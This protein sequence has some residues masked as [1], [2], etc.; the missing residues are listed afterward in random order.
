LKVLHFQPID[1]RGWFL[2]SWFC[3]NIAITV[4]QI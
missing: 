1:S 4:I 2:W 3:G